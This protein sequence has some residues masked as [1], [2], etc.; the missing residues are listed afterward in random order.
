[1]AP[2]SDPMTLPSSIA[3]PSSLGSVL[4]IIFILNGTHVCSW[5]VLSAS[6]PLAKSW[7]FHGLLSFHLSSQLKMALFLLIS[8]TQKSCSSPCMS[9]EFVPIDKRH[10]QIPPGKCHLNS[11][12]LLRWLSYPWFTPHIASKSPLLNWILWSSD[13]SEKRCV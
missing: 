10:L 7:E 13:A 11:L 5:V 8:H 1:M 2:P 12:L 4:K 3:L 6:F 9:W